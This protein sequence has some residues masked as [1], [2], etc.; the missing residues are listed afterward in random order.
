MN[1]ELKDKIGRILETRANDARQNNHLI[2]DVRVEEI[3]AALGI[4]G[5]P[6]LVSEALQDDNL[7][8]LAGLE[9]VEIVKPSEEPPSSLAAI[10]RYQVHA[11]L[12]RAS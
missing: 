2:L 7:V 5:I 6:R 3:Q 12:R 10:F 9:L 8:R 1:D 4:S 11:T